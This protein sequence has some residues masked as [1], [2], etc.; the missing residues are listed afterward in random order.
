M[1]MMAVG[2]WVMT[3]LGSMGASAQTLEGVSAQGGEL[4]SNQRSTYK[5]ACERDARLIYRAGRNVTVEWRQQI[6]AT[7][8]AYVQDCLAKAG[9]MP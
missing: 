9:L 7:R 2:V 1:R 8:K 5:A 6:K 4:T 3:M